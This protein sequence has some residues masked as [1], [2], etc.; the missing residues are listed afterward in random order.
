MPK[1]V[2]NIVFG[3][4]AKKI[5]RASLQISGR[6]ESISTFP[7]DLSFGP[8]NP[9]N[10]A[11]RL[12]WIDDTFHLSPER[13]GI[14][15]TRLDGWFDLIRNKYSTIVCWV[16]R[17]SAYECCGLYECARRIRRKDFYFIDTMAI[18]STGVVNANM[19][20]LQ[21]AT[22]LAHMSPTIAAQLIGKES[23]VSPSLRAM[24]RRT[25]QGL[26]VENAPFRTVGPHGISSVS[27]SH[28]DTVLL[29]NVATEW[30]SVRRVVTYA[31]VEA[32]QNNFFRVDMMALT[33]RLQALVTERKIEARG[34]ISQWLTAEVRLLL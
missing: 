32:N 3:K 9:P 19:L 14:F 22:R 8:I 20:D 7:D 16:C 4:L 11:R 28:F 18:D 30:R 13:W 2:V 6:R 31:A 15:P 34:D 27:I 23:L 10:G 24:W 12:K 33:G 29:S 5:L 1:A 21:L 25:W 26:R 17:H